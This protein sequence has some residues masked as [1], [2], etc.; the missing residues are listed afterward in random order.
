MIEKLEIGSIVKSNCGRD[1]GLFFVV[2]DF[3]NDNFREFALIANGKEHKLQHP[4]K[5]NIK[6]LSVTNKK[7]SVK[8]LTNKS[9]KSIIFRFI[10][11]KHIQ[12]SE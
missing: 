12:E 10:S 6:H 8:C 9:L 1:E 5:K 7:I 11:E 3:Q 2:L 4:K